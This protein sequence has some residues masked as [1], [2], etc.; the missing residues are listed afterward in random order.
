MFLNWRAI[1]SLEPW[2]TTDDLKDYRKKVGIYFIAE[3]RGTFNALIQASSNYLLLPK[4]CSMD[5]YVEARY[6]N[7]K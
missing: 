3:F 6:I 2:Q 7:N 4:L 5:R 1:D